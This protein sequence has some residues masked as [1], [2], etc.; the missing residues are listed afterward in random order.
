[1]VYPELPAFLFGQLIRTPHL[2]GKNKVCKT[3]ASLSVAPKTGL[4]TVGLF[5]DIIRNAE[6]FCKAPMRFLRW[7]ALRLRVQALGKM[8][9]VPFRADMS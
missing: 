2:T 3:W 7:T 4:Q 6:S 8:S 5:L 1:M 9:G